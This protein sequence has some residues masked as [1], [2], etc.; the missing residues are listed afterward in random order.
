MFRNARYT[1]GSCTRAARI[2]ALIPSSGPVRART[3]PGQPHFAAQCAVGPFFSPHTI[4]PT[5]TARSTLFSLEDCLST[6][7]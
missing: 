7:E 1:I 2:R 6:S 5:S 4:A 3:V